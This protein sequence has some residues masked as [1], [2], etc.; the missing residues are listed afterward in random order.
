MLTDFSHIVAETSQC[1]SIEASNGAA[2]SN[3]AIGLSGLNAIDGFMIDTGSNIQ[4]GHRMF[5]LAAILSATSIGAVPL[6]EGHNEI[7]SVNVVTHYN[8]PPFPTRDGVISWP[9]TGYFSYAL[10]PNRWSYFPFT[11]TMDFTNAGVTVTGPIGLISGVQIVFAGANQFG[12]Y[13]VFEVPN[14]SLSTQDQTY[15]AN[16]KVKARTDVRERK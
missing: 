5:F 13:I 8:S 7:M 16:T 11:S 12:N 2:T 10:L 14:I 3:L 4:V 1:Y 6:G 15:C 9:T